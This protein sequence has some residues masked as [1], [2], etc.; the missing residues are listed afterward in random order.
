MQRPGYTVLH[1]RN[2]RG[3]LDAFIKE[4]LSADYYFCADDTRY[5]HPRLKP[6]HL[7]RNTLLDISA[8]DIRKHIQSGNSIRALVPEPVETYIR[9]KGLYR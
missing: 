1:P 5:V 4:T 2:D 3:S 9:E 8:T 7:F 6:I